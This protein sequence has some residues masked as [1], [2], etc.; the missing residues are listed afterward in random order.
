MVNRFSI[1]LWHRAYG[2]GGLD[3]YPLH[4]GRETYKESA[5]T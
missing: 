3:G 2:D 4:A 5:A 1:L